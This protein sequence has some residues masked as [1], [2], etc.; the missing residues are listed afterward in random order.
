MDDA[1]FT[2]TVTIGQWVYDEGYQFKDIICYGGNTSVN[3]RTIT[4][5]KGS[6]SDIYC[7][8]RLKC[9]L[10]HVDL[11][12]KS[13]PYTGNKISITLS[14]YLN[15][16]K[17]TLVENTDYVVKYIKIKKG[18]TYETVSEIKQAGR[19]QLTLYGKGDNFTSAYHTFE[20]T[21]SPLELTVVP[22]STTK[23]YSDP[24]PEIPYTIEGGTLV[25]GDKL[26]GSLSY[27]K[28]AGENVGKHTITIGSL[29]NPNYNITL[30]DGEFEILPKK[31][32]N[33]VVLTTSSKY[34]Y[35]GAEIKPAVFVF[36]GENKIPASEYS[37][38][39]RNNIDLGQ[40]IWLWLFH[41]CRP[42]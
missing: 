31:L 9:P 10:K 13:T 38:S 11:E 26:T 40:G 30:A 18:D 2:R 6:C 37:V 8:V 21:V 27:N 33:A 1:D 22:K 32:A 39:Y 16:A 17:Y 28:S 4:V 3:G 20:F 25:S 24:D 15:D 23:T 5:K 35:T 41:Y 34:P 42:K 14:C 7:L 36:D 12:K 19:Y 29:N